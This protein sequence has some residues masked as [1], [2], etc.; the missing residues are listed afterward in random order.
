MTQEK[1]QEKHSICTC[2]NENEF[3]ISTHIFRVFNQKIAVHNLPHH[4]CSYCGT[5][6][7]DITCKI[8]NLLKEAY[9]NNQNEIRYN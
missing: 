3:L 4:K 2:G 7:I 8:S 6:S 9:N 1:P 5:A